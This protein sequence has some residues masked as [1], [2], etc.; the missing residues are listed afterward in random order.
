MILLA[1]ATVLVTSSAAPVTR[2]IPERR[3]DAQLVKVTDGDTVVLR[4]SV[5]ATVHLPGVDVQTT[6]AVV[7]PV[8]IAGVNT[9]ELSKP[10]CEKE[11]VAAQKAKAFLEGTLKGAK[12]ALVTRGAESDKYGRRLG[13]IEADGQPVSR[14]LISAG[15]ADQYDGGHRDPQRWCR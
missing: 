15:L 7:E 11:R 10:Q 5:P 1:L 4:I 14:A 6:M 3:Y 2:V 9:P 13:D 12:L 8:R